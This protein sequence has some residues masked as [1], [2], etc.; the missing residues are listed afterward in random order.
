MSRRKRVAEDLVDVALDALRSAAAP[1]SERAREAVEREALREARRQEW[2][3]KRAEAGQRQLAAVG[4]GLLVGGLVSLVVRV[5]VV[6]VGAGILAASLSGFLLRSLG[7]L[8]RSAPKP[9]VIETPEIVAKDLPKSRRELVERLL[10]EATE[11][12]RELDAIARDMRE[13]DPEAAHLLERL[14]DAGQ[15][16]CTGAAAAPEKFPVA[17]RVFTQHLPKA[18][19]IAQTHLALRHDPQDQRAQE[20]R[21][22][23][24]RMEALFEKVVLDLSAFDPG[25]MDLEIRLANQALDE[26][27]NGP[28]LRR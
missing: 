14:V 1:S 13:A 20:A 3:Q 16:V 12:L 24:A 22:V 10:G 23:L 15:R 25:D 21:H 2:R 26:D 11:Q 17:Q 19:V 8:F 4:V 18:V 5:P 6:A 27:L 28:Q 9:R 7:A